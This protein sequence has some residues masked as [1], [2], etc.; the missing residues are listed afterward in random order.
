MVYLWLSFSLLFF[1]LGEYASKRW[2][3]GDRGPWMAAALLAYVLSSLIWLPCLARR[4]QLAT[5]GLT[6]L[7]A[8]CVVTVGLGMLMGETPSQRQW[9]GILAAAVAVLLLN[10]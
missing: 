9:W 3:N 2:A 1:G 7:A 8:G 6:W 10:G 4:N 5:L